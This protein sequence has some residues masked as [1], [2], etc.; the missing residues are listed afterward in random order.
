MTVTQNNAGSTR[1]ARMGAM[2]LGMGTL[3]FV[4]PKPF[5]TIIPAELP[6]SARF[7]TYA[8]G[9]AELATGGLLLVPRT[10]RLGG[11]AALA[12]FVGVFPGNVNMVRLWW[13]KPWPLRL[14]AIARLPLQLPMVVAALKVWRSP[15]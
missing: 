13:N 14:V 10:R 12:L 11:L 2:L 9:V 8:S 5:D 3:H 1:A 15:T 6:G 4:A 7:Y